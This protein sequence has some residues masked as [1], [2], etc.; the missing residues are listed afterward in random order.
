MNKNKTMRNVL[1]T[2]ILIF[3][4][5][6]AP[7]CST[8]QSNADNEAIKRAVLD[9]VEGLYN[10]DSTLIYRGAS[11]GIAK[12]GVGSN[13]KESTTIADNRLDFQGLV[14]LAN[15]WNKNK[16]VNPQTA[17]KE[18]IIYEVLPYSA[19]VKLVASWGVDYMHLAKYDGKWK[20]VNV[21]WQGHPD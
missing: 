1:L 16:E 12:M 5:Y 10:A 18:V 11:K 17:R 2:Y 14:D 4:A 3:L 6:M 20:I 7:L 9:Y 21:L 15:N 13:S 19:S 8:A